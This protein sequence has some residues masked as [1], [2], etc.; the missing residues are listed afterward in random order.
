MEFKDFKEKCF[1]KTVNEIKE[2]I[3]GI[4]NFWKNNEDIEIVK[5]IIDAEMTAESILERDKIFTALDLFKQKYIIQMYLLK[6]LTNIKMIPEDENF[7]DYNP[8][9]VKAMVELNQNAFLFD[10]MVKDILLQK[11]QNVLDELYIMFEKGL[12]NKE[13]L[14]EI[15]NKLDNMFSNESTENLKVIENILAYNDPNLKQIK[16]FVFNSKISMN[17]INEKR[18]E[19]T[20]KEDTSFNEQEKEALTVLQETKKAADGV[21]QLIKS[22]PVVEEIDSK[23]KQEQV[24]RI[25]EYNKKLEENLKKQN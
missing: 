15:K 19:L 9:I 17:D 7:D 2:I 5:L 8:F 24:Q 23:I 10:N 20:N 16:D 22:V 18:Q 14:D 21:E 11:Q 6:E 13:E 3:L 1:G 25:L 4:D 12:P